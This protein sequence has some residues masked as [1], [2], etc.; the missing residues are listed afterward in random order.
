MFS[1][2]FL[3][4]RNIKNIQ[5]SRRSRMALW[6]CPPALRLKKK[7]M[8]LIKI[9]YGCLLLRFV[10]VVSFNIEKKLDI[11]LL[12]GNRMSINVPSS[13]KMSTG[14]KRVS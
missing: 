6:L 11:F 8:I 12:N 2:E 9:Q 13:P 10:F 1:H 7:I 5:T 4:K 3:Q 14:L